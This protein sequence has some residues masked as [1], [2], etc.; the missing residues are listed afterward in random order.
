MRFAAGDDVFYVGLAGA[1][2]IG[3]GVRTVDAAAL[4]GDDPGLDTLRVRIV[5]RVVGRAAVFRRYRDALQVVSATATAATAAAAAA[6]G[7]WWRDRR[8]GGLWAKAGLGCWPRSESSDMSMAQDQERRVDP[9]ALIVHTAELQPGAAVVASADVKP[10][11]PGDGA[12]DR[13]CGVGSSSD[14]DMIAVDNEMGRG[15]RCDGRCRCRRARGCSCR[16]GHRRDG[17]CR[18]RRTRGCAGRRGHRRVGR[19]RC[20]RACGCSGRHRYRR[21][22]RGRGRRACGRSG[23]RGPWRVGRGCGRRPARIRRLRAGRGPGGGPPVRASCTRVDSAPICVCQGSWSCVKRT[24]SRMR[25]G[26]NGGDFEKSVDK[27]EESFHGGFSG[28]GAGGMVIRKW[29][30]SA[31]SLGRIYSHQRVSTSRPPPA[32]SSWSCCLCAGVREGGRVRREF[33]RQTNWSFCSSSLLSCQWK[34]VAALHAEAS[35]KPRPPLPR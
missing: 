1:G 11:A 10:L 32:R 4:L 31:S 2:E 22:V 34:R 28:C 6:V 3:A 13:K 15:H 12:D 23:R 27:T 14:I 20:R 30:A 7:R 29:L 18:C 26:D 17:R 16:R 19:G 9:A 33:L 35:R 5:A 25:R 8:I 21:V 24:A